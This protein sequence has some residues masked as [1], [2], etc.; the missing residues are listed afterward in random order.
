MASDEDNFDIDI[1]GDA[2]PEENERYF[3][4]DENDGTLEQAENTQ[5]E[6]GPDN[7]K[8]QE[9]TSSADTAAKDNDQENLSHINMSVTGSAQQHAAV[10][11][12]GIKRKE[13]PD[14]R[15]TDPGATT[16]VLLSDLHWWTTEDEIRSWADQVGCG[17]ELKDVTFSEHKV[18]GKSKG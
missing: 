16:A 17:E 8:P 14:D 9:V 2:G 6:I 18:N 1:Y 12:Q 7:G 5:H 4:Q 3:K 10:P 15:P 11:Q 13:S